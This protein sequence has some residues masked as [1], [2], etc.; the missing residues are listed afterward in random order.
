MREGD[1]PERPAA[2]EMRQESEDWSSEISEESLAFLEAEHRAFLEESGLDLD[3]DP[4]EVARWMASLSHSEKMDMMD[5]L[6]NGQITDQPGKKQV[7][8]QFTRMVGEE[9][10]RPEAIIGDAIEHY[11]PYG[12]M[13]ERIER[14]TGA[15]AGGLA[16]GRCYTAVLRRRTTRSRSRRLPGR[17]Y[18][19]SGF[20]FERGPPWHDL[21]SPPHSVDRSGVP[22]PLPS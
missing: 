12:S 13:V 14:E 20:G 3:P 22:G 6:E 19:H 8:G 9:G 18:R 17:S 2:L 1:A 11:E 21:I 5:F 10:G 4:E 7:I 16:N 15:P